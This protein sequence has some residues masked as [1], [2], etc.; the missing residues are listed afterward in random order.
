MTEGLALQASSFLK[1]GFTGHDA[2]YAALAKELEGRWLTFDDKA[3]QLIKASRVSHSLQKRLPKD[4][5][6]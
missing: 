4:W 3:H 2:C 6:G 5:E 1:R